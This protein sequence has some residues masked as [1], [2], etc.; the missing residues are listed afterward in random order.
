MNSPRLAV[1]DAAFEY[2]KGLKG[3]SD[4]TPFLNK[5][6]TFDRARFLPVTKNLYPAVLVYSNNE[7]VE[8]SAPYGMPGERSSSMELIVDIRQL[9]TAGADFVD[10]TCWEVELAF[11]RNPTLHGAAASTRFLSFESDFSPDDK[12]V[13]FFALMTFRVDLDVIDPEAEHLLG[14][15]DE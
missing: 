13:L 6:K 1:R 12:T 8:Q 7:R 11:Q 5:V 4:E 14:Y 9:G 10:E 3:Q 15:P 2:L